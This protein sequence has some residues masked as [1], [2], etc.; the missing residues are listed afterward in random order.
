MK[1]YRDPAALSGIKEPVLTLGNFDGLHLGHLKIIRG[2][3]ARARK[4]GVSS[5]VYTF[6]PHPLKVVSPHKSPPLLI[7]MEDKVRLIEAA[8]VDCL[9]FASFTRE[10]AAK[11]PR[12]FVEE[13]IVPLSVK[14]VWVGHD[15]RFGSGKAGTVEH[16]K[17]LG[18]EFGFR[19]VV[20]GAYR[21]GGHIVSSSRIRTLIA[22]GKVGE[23]AG[24]LGRRY[25]VK[26]V[27]V[28]GANIGKGIGFPTANLKVESE[29]VPAGGVY[30][31]WAVVG[32]KRFPAVLNI[33]RAPTFGGKET[34]VEVHLLDFDSDL[35]GERMEV[36]FIRRLRS[37]KKFKSAG[38]LA[39]Q[40]RKDT[41]RARKIFSKAAP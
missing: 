27:V 30:A 36:H 38:D 22:E 32:P 37:E 13:A 6:D 14:E 9:I 26:G 31:A 3:A 29:L 2:V 20:I 15:F 5:V 24:L 8:G 41:E 39:A 7:D 25:S 33:G 19:V 21:K 40:I 23:A 34:S 4:L 28:K 18:E 16:L 17:E 35:Y 10:F 1:I 12:Q 11:H